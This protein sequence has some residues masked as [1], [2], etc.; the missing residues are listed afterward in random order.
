MVRDNYEQFRPHFGLCLVLLCTRNVV[1]FVIMM[2]MITVVRMQNDRF[3][4][5]WLRR[6]ADDHYMKL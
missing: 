3:P 6:H 1:R 5:Y 2:I 4:S